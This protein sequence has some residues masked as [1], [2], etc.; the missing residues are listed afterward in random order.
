MPV[1][2]LLLAVIGCREMRDER[3]EVR[4][5]VDDIGREVDI[6]TDPRRVVSLAPSITEIVFAAGA[7]D[8]LGAVTTADDYPPE[9]EAVKKVTAFP[10]DFEGLVALGPDLILATDQINPVR[11]LE[12]LSE[13][14][15][16]TYFLRFYTASDVFAAVRT[17]GEILGNPLEGNRA[18]DSLETVWSEY[19]ERAETRSVRPS[20]LLLAGHDVL[21]AFGRESYTNEM[22]E[23][24]GGRSVTEKL[25]GQAVTLSDEFVLAEQPEF[26]IGTFGPDFDVSLILETHA[27]WVELP[28]FRKQNVYSIDP[29]I[30]SR[31][32]PR[33][34]DGVRKMSGWIEAHRQSAKP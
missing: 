5:T 11:E 32:G 3:V 12:S 4:A 18:A 17:A 19:L 28:A 13:L 2:L 6:P 16:P 1:T 25:E 29:D 30:V 27:T 34:I 26:I 33:I 7:G 21:Y 31:P 8:R 15:I 9:V 10:L 23:A 14:G 20:V 22:I 24:A